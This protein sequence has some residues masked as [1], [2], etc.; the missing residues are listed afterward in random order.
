MEP[1][2]TKV[3]SPQLPSIVTKTSSLDVAAPLLHKK[4]E[5]S[6]KEVF[7]EHEQIHKKDVFSEKI[8]ENLEWQHIYDVIDLVLIC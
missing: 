4:I 2:F 6:F 7:N 1:F 8:A 5:F 3:N